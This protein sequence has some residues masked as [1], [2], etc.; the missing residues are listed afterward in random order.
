MLKNAWRV[1]RDKQSSS[2]Q[3]CEE[4]DLFKIDLRVERVP[5]IAVLEDQG[6][7]TKIQDL[8]HTLRTQNRTESV[9]A[10]LLSKT[11]KVQYVQ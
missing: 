2:E 3:S 6:R 8:V 10:D 4:G 7:V 11:G 5:Q 1:D 9:F